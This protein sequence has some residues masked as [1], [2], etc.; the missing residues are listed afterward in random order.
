[1]KILVF[2]VTKSIDFTMLL[3]RVGQTINPI[4]LIKTLKTLIM[5]KIEQIKKSTVKEKFMNFIKSMV[6]GLALVEKRVGLIPLIIKYRF[7]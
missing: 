3:I 4:E 5:I 6:V 1:M 7:Q 2:K